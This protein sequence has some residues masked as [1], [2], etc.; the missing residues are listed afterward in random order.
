M[1]K[2]FLFLLAFIALAIGLSAA[3]LF[4]RTNHGQVTINTTNEP[5]AGG[6][7]KVCGQQFMIQKLMHNEEQVINFK[8]KTDSHYEIV[9][10]F[11]SGRTISKNIGY[12]TNGFDP[13]DRLLI[14]ENDV[15]IIVDIK[16]KRN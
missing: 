3:V 11:A 6:T 12:V 5:L 14:K 13:V 9:L 8:I 1:R 2:T 7:L 16:N 10:R 4:F 15:E